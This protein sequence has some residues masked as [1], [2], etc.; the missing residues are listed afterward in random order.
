MSDHMSLQRGRFQEL[1][2]RDGLVVMPGGCTPLFAR[3]A[4]EAGFECFFLAGSQTSAFV[5]GVPDVGVMGLRDMADH[6]RSVA[7]HCDIPVLVDGDTGYGGAVNVHYAVQ[8]FV[9]SGAAALQIEDQEAPKKSG[10]SAGRRLIP[11]DEAVGKYRAA[12]DARDSLDPSFAICARTDAIGAEGGGFEEGVERAA[13]YVREGG[14]DFV[15]LNSAQSREELREAC[16]RIPAPVLTSW[17]GPRPAPTL[18]ELEQLGVRIA[19]YPVVASK[20]GA[21]AVWEL[22]HDFRERG[23]AAIEEWNARA[24]ESRW[25][26]VDMGRLVGADGVRGLEERYLPQDQRRD[27]DTTFGHRPGGA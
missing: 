21:Q 2:R 25:G 19:L 14:V 6:A 26:P 16:A 11:V 5:Y 20:P 9:R 7:A 10:T 1:L 22:L 27:Y 3:M 17:G 8:E 18:D 23:T 13:A 24:A 15:W 12:V 4:Q